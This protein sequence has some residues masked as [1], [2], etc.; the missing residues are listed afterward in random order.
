VVERKGEN[1]DDDKK[2]VDLDELDQFHAAS[3]L[4]ELFS[5]HIVNDGYT[6]LANLTMAPDK[7]CFCIMHNKEVIDWFAALHNAYPAIAAELRA[8]RGKSG[9]TGG[10]E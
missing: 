3:G 9:R 2:P 5:M 4:S 8:L 10:G 6:H 1:M 7:P